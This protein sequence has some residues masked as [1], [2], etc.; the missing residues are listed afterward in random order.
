MKAYSITDVTR[1]AHQPTRLA[2]GFC[3]LHS[4]AHHSTNPPSTTPRAIIPKDEVVHNIDVLQIQPPKALRNT[5]GFALFSCIDRSCTTKEFRGAPFT[6]EKQTPKVKKTEETKNTQRQEEKKLN[7]GPEILRSAA[8]S[9][10]QR[11]RNY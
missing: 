9:F 10:F 11:I 5:C 6:V 8:W 1:V 2:S 4:I 7:E 3:S